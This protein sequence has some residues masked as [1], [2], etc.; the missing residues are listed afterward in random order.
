MI[1]VENLNKSFGDKHVLKNISCVFQDAK[2]NLIIGQS[3]SGKTVLVK[4]LIGLIEPD[5]G[6]ICYGDDDFIAMSLKE[7]KNLRK[8]LGMVFQGGALFDSVNVE[9]NVRFPLE[10]FSKMSKA[11]MQKRVDFCLDRVGVDAAK[12]LPAEISGGMQKRVAIARAIALNPQYL[13]CDEPNSGLDPQ[14][15]KKIDELLL[16]ITHDF[17]ITTVIN[18][19]DM[20][21]VVEI[22]ERIVFLN[23]GEIAWRGEGVDIFDSDNQALKEF[24]FANKQMEE[25]REL[26]KPK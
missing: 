15:S 19:H 17:G 16:E 23:K 12:S 3:G 24:I 13:F 25:L 1:K 18:T 6:S 5:S 11:E 20:N 26:K 7:K 2:I 21:S 22:G 10:M 8:E 14:T 4:S 9:D